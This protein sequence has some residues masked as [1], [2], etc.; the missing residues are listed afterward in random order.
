MTRLRTLCAS[1]LLFPIAGPAFAADAPAAPVT[2]PAVAPV[3][4]A[5]GASEAAGRGAKEIVEA[6]TKGDFAAIIDRTVEAVV[7]EM[8]GRDK[9]VKAIEDA[10]TN[11]KKQGMSIR[12]AGIGQPGEAIAE[13][14]NTFV[15]VPTNLEMVVPKGRVLANSYLLGVSTDGGATWKFADGGAVGDPAMRA[16]ILPKL[17]EKLKLPEPAQPQFIK[18]ET[19]AKAPEKAPETTPEKK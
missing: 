19:P 7:K 9:A 15:V 14:P 17:P 18:E 3:A 1:L 6:T 16:K 10:F 11:M 13:G 12:T 2:P 5:P 8:G 4:I